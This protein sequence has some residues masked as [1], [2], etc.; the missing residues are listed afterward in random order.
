MRLHRRRRLQR[1]GVAR[2]GVPS[3]RRRQPSLVALVL[4]DFSGTLNDNMLKMIVS[5]LAVE[6]PLSSGGG[7]AYLSLAGA[8]FILPY[9][10]FSGCAGTMTDRFDKRSVLVATKMAEIAVMGLALAALVARRL[11]LLLV[12]LFLAATSAT[13]S[14]P[15]KFAILPEMLPLGGL[16]RANGMLQ[17]GHHLAIVLGTGAGGALIA[18]GSDRPGYVGAMLIALAAGGAVASLCVRPVMRP[19]SAAPFALNP[20]AGLLAGIR[21]LAVDRTLSSAVAGLTLIDALS[22]LVLMDMLVVSKETLRIDDLHIGAL[23][24]LAGLGAG[25]GALIAGRLSSERIGPELA[26]CGGWGAAAAMLALF[27]SC[28]SFALAAVSLALVGAAGGLMYVP[29]NTLLQHEAP[30]REKG[31]TISTSNFL[32]M[33][34]VLTAAGTLWLLRDILGLRADSIILVCSLLLSVALMILGPRWRSACRS[35]GYEGV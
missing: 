4:A 21:R 27:L 11:D 29:L 31:H 26:V 34:G 10:L 13:F 19:G 15:A 18:L 8:V 30:A 24:A 23:A 1:L 32:N 17:M 20:F 9:L 25:A 35:L 22:T 2:A 28:H 7:G 6:A 14:S 5:I 16:A 33:V 3:G 12:A